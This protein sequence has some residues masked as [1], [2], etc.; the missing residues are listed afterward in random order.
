[1]AKLGRQF[2]GSTLSEVAQGTPV[3]SGGETLRKSFP[4][5][6]SC[7]LL[8]QVPPGAAQAA[9]APLSDNS[10]ATSGQIPS[11]QM[12]PAVPSAD[13]VDPLP[14]W[15]DG[16]VRRAILAYVKRVS[17]CGSPAWIPPE[18]R[19]AVLDNDGTLWP[20]NPIPIQLAYLLDT[21]GNRVRQTPSLAKDPA[22]S[23]ALRGD[24]A[25]VL[26]G[27]GSEETMGRLL[28]LTHAGMTPEEFRASV[29]RWLA[30]ARHPRFARPY[31]ALAYQPM[32]ELLA[33]LRA[34]GFRTWIVS[35][36]GLDFMRAFSG[37]LYGIPPEQVIGSHGRVRFELQDGQP[38]LVKTIDQLFV[39]DKAGKPEAIHTFIGRRPV[40][41]FGNSD[42]DLPMLQYGTMDQPRP[43][44][45]LLV[46]HTDGQREYAYDARP[47]SSGKLV[48]GLRQAPDRGWLV[49]D[50]ARD[51]SVVFPPVSPGSATPACR[52]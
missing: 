1:M 27:P 20:E 29:A 16:A 42:G 28:S 12:P 25:A 49:V 22:V 47:S 15:K 2:A 46:H 44:L 7:A 40:A 3:V 6:L 4:A 17:R 35:G 13:S 23:A 34:H 37:C 36:G 19:I 32:L 50:M 14:S 31:T 45:G 9:H 48:E 43:S 30:T 21:L 10:C 11:G 33:L 5:L 24:L 52:F 39:D 41:V 26:K 51:W 18:E 8:L 38:R